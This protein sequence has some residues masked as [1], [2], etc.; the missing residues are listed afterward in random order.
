MGEGYH[1]D[2]GSW[3]EMDG[4]VW[5]GGC[6]EGG[7]NFI[8]YGVK[9]SLCEVVNITPFLEWPLTFNKVAWGHSA[10]AEPKY[11]IVLFF[12]VGAASETENTAATDDFSPDH[13]FS[14]GE[15]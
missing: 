9:S 3:I 10:H 6:F 8:A 12:L 5:P 15:E 11:E 1:G 13:I 7:S 2:V 14:C 4:T